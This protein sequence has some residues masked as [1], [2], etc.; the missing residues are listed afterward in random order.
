[1]V[2]R[3]VGLEEA[4]DVGCWWGADAVEGE[5]TQGGKAEEWGE[6]EREVVLLGKVEQWELCRAAAV[7]FLGV[8]CGRNRGLR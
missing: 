6:V 3:W 8:G 7:R 5:G 1:M 2:E 4:L